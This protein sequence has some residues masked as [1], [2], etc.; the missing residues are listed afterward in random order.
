MSRHI[1]A[2]K[3]ENGKT[4]YIKTLDDPDGCAW[5]YDEVCCN[6]QSEHCCDFPMD[7]DCGV[8]PLFERETE[9]DIKR[10]KEGWITIE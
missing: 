5:M 1:D 8:C 4:K 10:L 3:L 9:E 6:D 2:E 7:E